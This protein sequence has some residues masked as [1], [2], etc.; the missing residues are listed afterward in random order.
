[1]GI[2]EERNRE[3]RTEDLR[4]LDPKRISGIWELRELRDE[5]IEYAEKAIEEEK[6]EIA[7]DLTEKVKEIDERLKVLESQ[8]KGEERTM[9]RVIKPEL[10]LN[11]IINN[12]SEEVRNFKTYLET[13]GT[14][15]EVKLDDGMAVVP[16]TIKTEILEKTENVLKLADLVTTVNVE[17]G[18]GEIPF[19]RSNAQPLPTVDELEESPALGLVPYTPIQFKVNT[20]RAY[21]T[22]SNEMRDDNASNLLGMVQNHFARAVVATDNKLIMDKLNTLDATTAT[23]GV[24]AIKRTINVE[25]LANGYQDLTILVNSSVYNTLDTMKDNN[26]RYIL[27]DTLKDSPY[28]AING[29]PVIVVPDTQLEGNKV[30]VGALKDAVAL[31]DRS[32]WNVQWEEYL[33]YGI[34]LSTAIRRDCQ[35]IDEESVKA[36]NLTFD[37]ENLG[38]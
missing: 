15:G 9:D 37:G 28:K 30:F 33:R 23:D 29:V 4:F 32:T 7:I 14:Q 18:K 36:I 5:A 8:D 13:R 11:G 10:H 24:D 17:T 25:L 1:M 6:P 19:L 34:S 21:I 31:F 38:A 16:E 12:E 35:L 3:L 2:S 27:Q 26:G 22:I 20:H